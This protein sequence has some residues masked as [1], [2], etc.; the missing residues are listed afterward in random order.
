MSFCTRC[1]GE[2]SEGA[3]C[4]T[5]C[6]C[7]VEDDDGAPI[8]DSSEPVAEDAAHPS[9]APAVVAPAARPVRTGG[10]RVL[11]IVVIILAVL[12]IAACVFLF[13]THAQPSSTSVQRNTS[14]EQEDTSSQEADASS[15]SGTS[16]SENG[17][18]SGTSSST[19]TSKTTGTGAS[20]TGGASSGPTSS[21]NAKLPS[22]NP[23]AAYTTDY[24]IVDSDTRVL[25][26]S[27]LR[28]YDAR[29]LK[30]ARNEIFARHGRIF[31]DAD[32]DAYFRSR[33][34]YTPS[35]PA[36]TFDADASQYLSRTEL[37]N[38]GLI[39]QFEKDN[40]IPL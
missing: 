1:G 23:Y 19:G 13:I 17:T 18:T 28:G 7:P 40:G 21:Q 6:G 2:L 27:D 9:A 16:G 15:V 11:L 35:V 12:L 38:A 36:E 5:R 24:I 33:H 14:V 3:R 39:L 4:C 37:N 22:S 29:Q 25:T 10:N 8:V 32:L 26:T 30:L 34:W 31:Q 20:T